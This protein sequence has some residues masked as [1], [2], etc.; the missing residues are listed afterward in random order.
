MFWNKARVKC[1]LLGRRGRRQW[2]GRW[3]GE[4]MLTHPPCLQAH[5]WPHRRTFPLEGRLSHRASWGNWR[6][7]FLWKEEVVVLWADPWTR[8]WKIW[9]PLLVVWPWANTHSLRAPVILSVTGGPWGL[10]ACWPFAGRHPNARASLLPWD[11]VTRGEAGP[12]FLC[13]LSFNWNCSVDFAS[14]L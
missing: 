14:V 8:N 7:P 6:S 10:H 3:G 5:I 1:E 4:Q 12:T 2:L 11:G 9:G 13:S